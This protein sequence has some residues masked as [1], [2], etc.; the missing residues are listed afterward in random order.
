MKILV[1][2][3][4]STSFKYRLIDMDDETVLAEGKIERIGRPGGDCPDYPTAIGRCLDALDR[5]G[6][7]PGRPGRSCRPSASRPST[8]AG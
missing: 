5:R 6:Q 1:P 4:G 3:I 7:A 8:P 2:N